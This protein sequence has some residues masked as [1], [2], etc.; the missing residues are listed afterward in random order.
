[1]WPA[2]IRQSYW[3][4]INY[5]HS[6]TRLRFLLCH[7]FSNTSSLQR[8]LKTFHNPH[9]NT[10]STIHILMLLLFSSCTTTFS[11]ANHLNGLDKEKESAFFSYNCIQWWKRETLAPCL[12]IWNG[13]KLL[14][15]AIAVS[16]VHCVLKG[17]V[18]HQCRVSPGQV[19][20]AGRE[21][22]YFS[23]LF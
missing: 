10:I 20:L 15:K 23:C 8:P 5:V 12:A 2:P 9:L 21:V 14:V 19:V 11:I 18:W 6:N 3:Y 17:E 7:I 1:M 16:L 4:A 22:H 13:G